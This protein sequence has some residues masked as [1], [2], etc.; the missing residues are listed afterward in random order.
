MSTID[1]AMPD[2]RTWAKHDPDRC[3]IDPDGPAVCPNPPHASWRDVLDRGSLLVAL[4]GA[5]EARD[6]EWDV[7]RDNGQYSAGVRSQDVHASTGRD[8]H[9]PEPALLRA[10]A[11]WLEADS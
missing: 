1:E 2:F 6:L 10:Y 11:L 5:I 7:E 8:H 4:I 9:G 3:R